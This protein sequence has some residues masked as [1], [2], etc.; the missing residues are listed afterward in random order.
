MM[1]AAA[2]HIPGQPLPD[3]LPDHV[4]LI[5]GRSI[6]VV[7]GILCGF[8]RPA[9]AV[10]LGRTIFVHPATTLTASLLRHELVHVR[11]WTSRGAFFPILYAWY[12]IRHG[13]RR[14]PFEIEAR[15]AE[16]AKPDA[17]RTDMSGRPA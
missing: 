4:R 1:R 5:R 14:N 8:R 2:G 17:E 7:G 15:M 12:H 13:Y 3:Q 11:Q 9:A 16:S 10:T 6:P